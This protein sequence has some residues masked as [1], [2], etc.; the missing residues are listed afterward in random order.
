MSAHQES[1][2]SDLTPDLTDN[3]GI[4]DSISNSSTDMSAVVM[5]TDLLKVQSWLDRQ[6]YDYNSQIE[7]GTEPV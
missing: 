4:D 3:V 1:K 2:S 5:V 6:L 7:S